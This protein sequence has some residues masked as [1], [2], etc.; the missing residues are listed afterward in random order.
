MTGAQRG[1]RGPPV[2]YD[3][4]QPSAKARS[5]SR[6]KDNYGFVVTLFCI[7]LTMP[8]LYGFFFVYH[9]AYI[10]VKVWSSY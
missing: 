8:S 4:P 6:R 2:S 3:D 1:S 10:S 5:L 7:K 9:Q